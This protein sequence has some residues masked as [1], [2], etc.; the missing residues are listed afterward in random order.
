MQKIKKVLAFLYGY[1]YNNTCVRKDAEKQK[2]LL[3]Q[4]VE[5]L[6]LNQGVRGSSPRRRM[7]VRCSL[8]RTFLFVITHGKRCRW[9]VFLF[10]SAYQRNCSGRPLIIGI[11]LL[12]ELFFSLRMGE[13]PTLRQSRQRIRHLSLRSLC[14]FTKREKEWLYRKTEPF[15]RKKVNF[16]KNKSNA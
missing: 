14:R 1:G 9:H 8:H 3:A 13:H 6:T 10:A 5:H 11:S 7:E 15:S 16:A 2:A 4:L 12:N